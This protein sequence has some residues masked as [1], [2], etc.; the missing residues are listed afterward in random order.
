MSTLIVCCINGGVS[1][2]FTEYSSSI[3]N[4]KLLHSNLLEDYRDIICIIPDAYF[5]KYPDLKYF[6]KYP[7]LKFLNKR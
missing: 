6:F 1:T 7:D 5:F 3:V 4:L 2:D